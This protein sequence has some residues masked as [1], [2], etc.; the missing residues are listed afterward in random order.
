MRRF[1]RQ[2]SPALRDVQVRFIKGAVQVNASPALLGLGVPVEVTG[3]PRLRGGRAIDFDASRVAVL[4]LGLPE[5]AVT[6]IEERINPLVDLTGMP[7]PVQ[8]TDVR[9]EGDRVV[10]AGDA[11]LNPADLQSEAG[12]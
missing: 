9:L 3:Q 4:R 1:V 12:A 8:L 7:F 6:R 10:V 11:S 5:F 2:R